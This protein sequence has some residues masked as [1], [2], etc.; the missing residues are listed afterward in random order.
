MGF[1]AEEMMNLWKTIGSIL[2]LGN[3]TIAHDGTDQARIPDPAQAEI[4]C[5]LLGIPSDS[6]IKALL[7]PRVRAGREWVTQSRNREQVYHSLDA[8]SKTLYERCFGWLVERIN[9][10][11]ER[12]SI[13][14]SFIG[15]LDIA[16]FEIFKVLLRRSR[17]AI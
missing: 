5:H 8:L 17:D 10:S 16:G 6:F 3:I 15:V 1:K 4:A 12:S 14:S 2:H 7:T 13:K 9:V 11:M